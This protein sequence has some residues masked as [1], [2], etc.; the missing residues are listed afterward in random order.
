MLDVHA[1]MFDAIDVD[2]VL[3]PPHEVKVAVLVQLS[4]VAGDK[5]TVIGERLGSRLLVVEVFVEHSRAADL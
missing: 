5:P 4:D 1:R 2:A 3:V